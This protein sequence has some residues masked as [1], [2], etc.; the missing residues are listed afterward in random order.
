MK[1]GFL[2]FTL[3]VLSLSFAVANQP[4][5]KKQLIQNYQSLNLDLY[6]PDNLY[7]TITKSLNGD[8]VKLIPIEKISLLPKKNIYAFRD[9]WLKKGILWPDAIVLSRGVYNLKRVYSL[10]NNKNVLEKIGK[11]A[12]ILKR[13]IYI[14]PTATLVIKDSVLKLSIKHGVNITYHGELDIVDSTVTSWSIKK[15]NYGARKELKYDEALLLTKQEPRPYILGMEGSHLT[16]LNSNIIGLGFKGS[17]GMY[18]ISLFKRFKDPQPVNSLNDLINNRKNPSGTI[19]G[20]NISKCFFGFYSNNAADVHILGNV[21]FENIVYGIDPH[22][23]TKRLIAARNI[24]YNTK[25]AHGIIFSREEDKSF[26]AENITFSNKGSGIMLDRKCTNTLIY[27][28]ISFNNEND[29]ISIVESD[30]NT[31]AN[32][33]IL[34]NKHNGIF[35]RNSID[36]EVYENYIYRNV[37]NGAEIIVSDISDTHTRDFDKDPFYE[38]TKVSFTKNY[39]EKNIN[40]V[41]ASKNGS[42]LFFKHNTIKNSG[43]NYFLGDI[44][45]YTA[46]I[47]IAN[48]KKGFLLKKKEHKIK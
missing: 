31:I 23:Y 3:F 33:I 12:Y 1:K 2:V 25:Y 36:I 5:D 39:F 40:S 43:P 20:C 4:L 47:L 17:S 8:S 44:E 41:L 13:P 15:G 42:K 10:L 38:R 6:K 27:K 18:G 30:N 29:G 14:S 7:K 21:F 45:K 19:V 32:N 16:M 26:I 24:T 28:N 22:D 9:I 11:N 46:E 37:F 34:R 48:N 35:I